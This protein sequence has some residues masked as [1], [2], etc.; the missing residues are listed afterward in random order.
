MP[1]VLLERNVAQQ[2]EDVISADLVV[3]IEIIPTSQRQKL[4]I[5]PNERQK[6]KHVYAPN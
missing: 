2:D 1:L 5:I 6:D 3:A 4:Q